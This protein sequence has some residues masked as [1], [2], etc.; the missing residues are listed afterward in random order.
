MS[1]TDASSKQALRPFDKAQGKLSSGQ[2][3]RQGSGQAPL[4]AAIAQ[5]AKRLVVKVGSAVLSK[6]DVG[7]HRPTVE[8]ICREMSSIK[9]EGRGGV[10]VSSG[11]ILAGM[12]RLG[13]AGR[14]G[15]IP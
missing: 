8:R 12:S 11:A 13:L 2:A 6:G 14:P 4:R 1:R 3:L 7:L 9:E 10:L 5:Q 15:S